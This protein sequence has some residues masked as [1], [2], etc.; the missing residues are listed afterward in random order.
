M[1][2]R[3]SAGFTLVEVIVTLGIFATL[4]LVTARIVGRVVDNFAMISTRGDRLIEIQRAMHVMQRDMLQIANRSVRDPL[5]DPR[6]PLLIQSDGTLEFTRAG[7]QNPLDRERSTLQRVVYRIEGDALFR[8]YF[9]NLDLTPDA[10]PQVQELLTGVSDLEVQAIDV[11]GNEYAFWPV[12]GAE[13]DPTRALAGIR[14]RFE[15]EP[16][17]QIERLWAVPSVR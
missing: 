5:G 6:E 13:N 14:L 2:R 15:L 11:A 16:F 4:G 9:F 17:G 8:A 10:S 12:A 1:M 7:W 3:R